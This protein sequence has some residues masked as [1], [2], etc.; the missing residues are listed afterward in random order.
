MLRQLGSGNI[1]ACGAERLAKQTLRDAIPRHA[2]ET[3]F[4]NTTVLQIAREVV[5]I[6]YAGLKNRAMRDDMGGD[7]TRYL[8][9][10]VS[11]LAQGRTA[12]DDMLALY[13]TTWGRRI[14]PIFKDYAF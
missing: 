8:D 3:P 1:S 10:V 5:K 4:R 11:R 2:L 13:E 7:E 6:A 14:D 9:P 12:A